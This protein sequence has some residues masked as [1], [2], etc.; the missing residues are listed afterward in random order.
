MSKAA[1]AGLLQLYRQILRAHA[2]V[3]PPPLRTMGD[4]YAKEEF[5]RHRDAKTTP[6]QWA[7]FM[8]EWQRY[9]SMLH[10]TADLPEGSGDIPEDVLQTLNEDQKRQLAR[11]QEEAARAREE[12]L[13]GVPPE[14]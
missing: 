12:I 9:L 4:A 5:R 6:A 10:G 14:A 2:T 13:K 8:Q 3:L 11:L 7:A 1:P